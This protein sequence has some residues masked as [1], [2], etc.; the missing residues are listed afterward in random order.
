[1]FGVAPVTGRQFACFRI[2]FG[3]Y[4]AIHFAQLIPYAGEMFS[5]AGALPDPTANPVYGLLPNALA[6][7]NTPQFATAF[8]AALTILSVLFAF[9][10]ARHAAAALL[11]YGWACLFNRNVLISNPSIPYVGLLLILVLLVPAREPLR[12]GRR[13]GDADFYVPAAV[14]WTAWALM[15]AGYTFSGIVKLESPS[16]IDGSALFHV[17]SSPLARNTPLTEF[18]LQQPTLLAWTA[19]AV[20]LLEG[21]F[22]PLV[23]A[24]RTR[25]LAWS[26][27]VALHLAI[28]AVIDFA[29]LSAGM[30]MLHLFTIDSRWVVELGRSVGGAA[31]ALDAV[32]S[33]RDNRPAPARAALHGDDRTRSADPGSAHRRGVA[34]RRH[35]AADDANRHATG[36]VADRRS[37]AR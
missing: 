28:V 36:W 31:S 5:G 22:V 27:M 21:L 24:R 18:M 6:H 1:M 37:G 12:L 15:S 30:L 25:A 17:L 34:H 23:V 3:A 16:W 32:H 2:V 13:D 26:G 9:G 11:W 35:V 33:W 19:W 4:L 10:I 20:L 7:W 29:D 14:F 8:V